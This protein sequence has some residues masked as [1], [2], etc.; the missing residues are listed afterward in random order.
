MT[1]SER[2]K[3]QLLS[4]FNE[5]SIDWESTNWENTNLLG[6]IIVSDDGTFLSSGTSHHFTTAN[7]DGRPRGISQ[8]DYSLS[9]ELIHLLKLFPLA[10]EF[11]CYILC[12]WCCTEA[13]LRVDKSCRSVTTVINNGIL[14]ICSVLLVFWLS[15]LIRLLIILWHT[16]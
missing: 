14:Y 12:T 7:M 5:G 11:G 13:Y 9:K 2:L 4:I 10:S 6:P 3:T 1:S 8:Q 16:F 15:Q